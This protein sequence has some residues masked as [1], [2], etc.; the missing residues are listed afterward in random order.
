MIQNVSF[1]EII[2]YEEPFRLQINLQSY[3]IK[4]YFLK[5]KSQGTFGSRKTGKYFNYPDGQEKKGC[6][7]D[8][9]SSF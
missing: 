1:L 9:N 3:L 6:Y 5:K 4:Y 8:V 2:N 7:Y